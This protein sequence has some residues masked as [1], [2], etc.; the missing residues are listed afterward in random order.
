MFFVCLKKCSNLDFE[1]CKVKENIKL[2]S[3]E[4]TFP[5]LRLLSS[6]MKHN[7][8]T[9]GTAMTLSACVLCMV[10]RLMEETLDPG[11]SQGH[12]LAFQRWAGEVGNSDCF[13]T[14]PSARSPSSTNMHPFGKFNLR[15]IFSRIYSTYTW[16][17]Y[18][19][20]KFAR[21]LWDSSFPRGYF[22][23]LLISMESSKKIYSLGLLWWIMTNNMAYSTEIDSPHFWRLES[24][25][26]AVGRVVIF[27]GRI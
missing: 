19:P 20:V 25:K 12:L 23:F 2:N 1:L 27:V 17:L 21:S 22:A 8:T 15:S 3:N 13:A 16:I 5:C 6:V 11:S 14:M 18:H 24:K 9:P 4:S 10:K 26:Q 7:N